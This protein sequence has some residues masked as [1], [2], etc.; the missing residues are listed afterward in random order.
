MSSPDMGRVSPLSQTWSWWW[1]A[2]P[3]PV[4]QLPCS[5][6]DLRSQGMYGACCWK[7]IY[8]SFCLSAEDW[9]TPTDAE[10]GSRCWFLPNASSIECQFPVSL[11]DWKGMGQLQGEAVVQ[12]PDELFR[13]LCMPCA[14][15]LNA[16]VLPH[17]NPLLILWGTCASS[18]RYKADFPWEASP[19]LY[20]ECLCCESSGSLDWRAS[21]KTESDLL[22][23]SLGWQV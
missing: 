9:S 6:G 16:A 23:C 18:W 10:E 1:G 17:C 22:I 15:C 20:L 3:W 2:A 7:Q 19:W 13:Q 21:L 14:G 5:E 11:R 8:L 4:W 12:L